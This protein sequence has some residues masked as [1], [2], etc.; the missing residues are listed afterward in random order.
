VGTADRG[1]VEEFPMRLLGRAWPRNVRLHDRVVAVLSF[2]W[3]GRRSCESLRTGNVELF[4]FSD[5]VVTE[6]RSFY[7]DTA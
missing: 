1:V 4:S 6:V 2:Q 3:R 5:G 7:A